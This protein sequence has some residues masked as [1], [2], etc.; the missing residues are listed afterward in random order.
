MGCNFITLMMPNRKGEDMVFASL[1][2]A[3]LAFSQGV[4]GLHARI[5][6]RLP[7]HRHV[8][9]DEEDRRPSQI[10]ETTY[11]RIMFNMILLSY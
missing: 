9:F 7:E 3:D 2:E 11:G 4:I 6:V 8:R 1:D 5:K 10:V